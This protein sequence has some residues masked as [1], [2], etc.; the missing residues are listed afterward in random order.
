MIKKIVIFRRT[1]Y[2]KYYMMIYK[3]LKL[4]YFHSNL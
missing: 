1:Y 2:I 3:A 4:I